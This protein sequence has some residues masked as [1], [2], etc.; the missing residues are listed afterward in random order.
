[1]ERLVPR[2]FE[3]VKRFIEGHHLL[4]YLLSKP[5]ASRVTGSAAHARRLAYDSAWGL[6]W[7][8]RYTSRLFRGVESRITNCYH[9]YA[10]RPRKTSSA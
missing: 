10:L 5:V 7:L 4:D 9:Q 1:M 8:I 3:E 6:R 2:D